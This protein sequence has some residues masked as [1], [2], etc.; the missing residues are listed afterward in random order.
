ML[1]KGTKAEDFVAANGKAF[2]K[3]LVLRTTQKITSG[4]DQSMQSSQIGMALISSLAFLAASFIIMTGMTTGV[5]ERQ[6]E[7]G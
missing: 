1:A 5:T 4:L 7:L 6:R 3:S 2:D